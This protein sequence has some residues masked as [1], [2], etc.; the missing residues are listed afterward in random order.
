MLAFCT[1]TTYDALNTLGVCNLSHIFDLVLV[2]SFN[3]CDFIAYPPRISF[4][5]PIY[6]VIAKC[7]A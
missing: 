6:F 5:L 3:D 2:N 4:F 7:K 1:V